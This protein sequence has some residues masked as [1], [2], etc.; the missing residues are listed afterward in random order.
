MIGLVPRSLRGRL[1]LVMVIGLVATLLAAGMISWWDRGRV[2]RQLNLDHYVERVAAVVEVLDD[3]D[4]D[5]RD[6]ILRLVQS[7]GFRVV[8]REA[9]PVA[10]ELPVPASSD[11]LQVEAELR[12]RLQREAV[13]FRIAP[14]PRQR[15]WPP[16]SGWYERHFQSPPMGYVALVGL[17]DGQAVEFRYRPFTGKRRP[18]RMLVSILFVLLAVTLLALLAVRFVARPLRTVTEQ[19]EQIGHDL[20]TPP[21]PETGP[22]EARRVAAAMNA[23]QQRIRDLFE[24]RGH[25][26]A[27]VSHDLRTPITR[28]RLRA[29]LIDDAE[30]RERMVRDLDEMQRMVQQ[31]LEFMRDGDSGEPLRKVDLNA[32]LEAL[33]EDVAE[34]GGTVHFSPRGRPLLETRPLALKRLLENLVANALRHGT[35]VELSLAEDADAVVIEVVDDGP[36]IDPAELERVFEPFYR[37]DAARGDGGTGLGLSIA[38]AIAGSLGGE[39]AL[40]NREH[41][42]LVA[43]LRLPRP[44]LY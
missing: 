10:D 1:M 8:L 7:P 28:M 11:A 36:G 25:F 35:R 18:P 14:M 19:A 17:V 23:M 9:L 27:A 22:T 41:G 15:Q 6:D 5:R 12:Q 37:V 21:M 30:L 44:P 42:G 43:R 33:V 2:T 16:R 26:L 13:L 40:A 20:D 38:R 32:L 34:G 31:T 4:A 29:E 39:L 24:Q 3:A